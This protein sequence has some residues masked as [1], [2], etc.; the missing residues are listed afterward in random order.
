MDH[1][2]SNGTFLGSVDDNVKLRPD[3]HYVLKDGCEITFGNIVMTFQS[4]SGG[5]KQSESKLRNS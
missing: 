4:A 5:K 1:N 2:S 3:N